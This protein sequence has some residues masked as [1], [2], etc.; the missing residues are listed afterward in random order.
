MY[1]GTIGINC[2]RECLSSWTGPRG[3]LRDGGVIAECKASRVR[4]SV[5]ERRAGD[6]CFIS[7]HSGLDCMSSWMLVFLLFDI[8]LQ[9]Q[10]VVMSLVLKEQQLYSTVS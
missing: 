3:R 1:V 4:C 7:L 10:S 6:L 8:L 2:A 9:A 5:S